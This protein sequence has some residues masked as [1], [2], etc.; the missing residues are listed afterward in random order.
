MRPPYGPMLDSGSL[1]GFS[2]MKSS[3][4]KTLSRS[5]GYL[6]LIVVG[7]C[8]FGTRIGPGVIAIISALS[9]IYMLFQAPMWCCAE[10][11]GNRLCR[12]NAYGILMGCHLRQHKWQK[13]KMVFKYSTWGKMFNQVIASVGGKAA[14]VSALAG[15]ASALVALGNFA[16]K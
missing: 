11:R 6:L 7:Y 12:N 14:T 3:T 13:L 15:S 9:V 5:W 2:T 10:A 4:K 1:S 8:W 16:F